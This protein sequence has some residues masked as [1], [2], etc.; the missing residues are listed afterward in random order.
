MKYDRKSTA[1]RLRIISGQVEGIARMIEGGKY[2]VDILNQSLAVQRALQQIDK[3]VLENHI[4]TCVIDQVRN[5]QSNK[6]TDELV[7]IYSLSRKS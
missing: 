7:K 2:C 6:A 5:G 3:G 1:H 4:N